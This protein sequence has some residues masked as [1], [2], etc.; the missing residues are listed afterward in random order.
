MSGDTWTAY[1][2]VT[3]KLMNGEHPVR[4]DALLDVAQLYVRSPNKA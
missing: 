4:F 2:C 3:T 1:I